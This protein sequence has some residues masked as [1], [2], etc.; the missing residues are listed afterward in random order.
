MSKIVERGPTV[1]LGISDSLFLKSAVADSDTD[2]AAA[3]EI[4]RPMQC[5][6]PRLIHGTF[7]TQKYWSKDG[8][9]RPITLSVREGH[10][11]I[12]IELEE[13]ERAC[14]SFKHLFGFGNRI[15][16]RT[17]IDL[18]IGAW[19]IGRA[20]Q[21]VCEGPGLV[22]F[23]CAGV[24]KVWNEGDTNE[25]QRVQVERLVFW[26]QDLEFRVEKVHTIA[27]LYIGMTRMFVTHH[28]S[29]VPLVLDV[30]E[31]AFGNHNLWATLKR[32]YRFW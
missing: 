18:G 31:R 28:G 13:G 10:N 25:G 7:V 4:T 15:R 19:A 8:S 30:D 24:P 1:T 27:D 26:P 23:D 32:L 14:F 12:A 29:G 11:L 21:H 2:L 22:V 6:L 16:F 5:A 20:I 9:V 3:G 17:V